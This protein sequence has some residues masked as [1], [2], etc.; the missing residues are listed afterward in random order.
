MPR[1]ACSSAP[2]YPSDQ[3]LF[4][5][6]E[7]TKIGKTGYFLVLS[8]KDHLIVS[9]SDKSRIMQ[10]LPAKGVN[11]LLDRRLAEGFEGPG[12]TT[13][14]LGVETLSVSRNMKTTGWVVVAA[15]STEEAFAP[16]A[17]L[18]RQIYLA[19]LLMSLVMM[20]ILRFVLARQMAPLEEAGAAM[21]R[22]TEGEEPLRPLP[23]RRADE[24]GRLVGHFNRLVAERR[25]AEE[26]IRELNETLEAKVAERTQGAG[27][28]Q[29]LGG[30]RPS[31]TAESHRRFQSTRPQRKR[32][33]A[34]PGRPGV[35]Q[36][37]AGGEPASGRSDRRLA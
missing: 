11:P 28:L 17:T 33:Q 22:M 5:Q 30:P 13:T 8:P 4:G 32:G 26:E 15:V 14:S 35:S 7:Q 23:V 6:L 36:A 31:R 10:A 25:R 34:G 1:S 12:V 16:I 3:N 19:A 37:R 2:A 20:V 24:I 9:A 18:K 29:L 21:R 27:G